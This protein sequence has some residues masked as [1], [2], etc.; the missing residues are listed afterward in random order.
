MSGEPSKEVKEKT[1]A[2]MQRLVPIN[3]TLKLA[4]KNHGEFELLASA[5]NQKWE[6]LLSELN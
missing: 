6:Q 1:Y 4:D 3:G 2:Q 5:C